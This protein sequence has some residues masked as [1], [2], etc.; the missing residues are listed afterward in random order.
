MAA[1]S[2][3]LAWRM[4]WTVEPGRLRSTG[5]KES[6]MSE[7]TWHAHTHMNVYTRLPIKRF[8]FQVVL[9]A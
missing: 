7:V 9:F 4:P 5:R 6:D 3:I 1:Y 2:S 8:F